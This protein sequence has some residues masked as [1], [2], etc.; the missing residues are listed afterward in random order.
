MPDSA[1]VLDFSGRRV[2]VA[3]GSRGIGRSIALAFAAAGAGVSF[4]ARGREALE[5]TR[6]Q[7]A[8]HGGTAHAAVCDLADAGDVAR[9]VEEAAAAL[10]GIDVLVNNGTGYGF[11]DDEDG[12]RRGLDVDIMG[13]VRAVRHA[14]PRLREAEGASILNTVSIAALRF[15]SSGAPYA[16]AK[17]AIAS[18]TGSLALELAADG[19]RV[20]AI[21]PGSIAFPGGL[22]ERRSREEPEL[23][24]SFLD[25]IPFGRMGKP[26][27]IA[28]AALFLAS[29][30]ASWV[31]GQTLVVD[32]GQM[33][34]G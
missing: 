9:Y 26:G 4:C 20:N 2:V 25:R 22:W 18:Y 10:G 31:T 32:G 6:A 16:A 21:A 30:L 34:N 5:A 17:A 27:D 14:L 1:P 28:N 29:P 24:R 15:R 12:W 3:A 13:T 33:L 23:Y 8:E 7:M 19:I 11:E